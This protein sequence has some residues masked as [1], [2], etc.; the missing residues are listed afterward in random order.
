MAD[1][2][3]ISPIDGRELVRRAT[4]TPEEIAAVL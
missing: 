4:A 2:V 3:C 1:L